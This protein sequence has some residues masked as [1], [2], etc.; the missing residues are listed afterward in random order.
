MHIGDRERGKQAKEET[1]NCLGT[2]LL[3]Q[4][5]FKH[6]HRGTEVLS[7]SDT[8]EP[9]LLWGRSVIHVQKGS[10]E[11][12]SSLGQLRNCFL[13]TKSDLLNHLAFIR[14]LLLCFRIFTTVLQ[15]FYI[16]F[17]LIISVMFQQ[18]SKFSKFEICP[19]LKTYSS[20][21]QQAFS[22]QITKI[23]ATPIELV[24]CWLFFLKQIHTGFIGKR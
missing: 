17:I 3:S 6:S 22:C 12:H 16:F 15:I 14:C 7:I 5:S 11:A 1:H 13:S 21:H 2:V 8:L 23:K 19:S 24:L 10:V 20:K 4:L 9:L 18:M